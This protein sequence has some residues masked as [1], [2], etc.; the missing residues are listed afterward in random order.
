[1][2]LFQGNR[3]ADATVFDDA[4]FHDLASLA[5]IVFLDSAVFTD[6]EFLGPSTFRRTDFRDDALFGGCVF[7]QGTDVFPYARLDIT[8]TAAKRAWP[9][10][11]RLVTSTDTEIPDHEGRW[12]EVFDT[13]MSDQDA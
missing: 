12:G 13:T 10:T 9:P 3:F 1:M 6:V 11:W 2:A 8:E 5:G 7:H 4:K